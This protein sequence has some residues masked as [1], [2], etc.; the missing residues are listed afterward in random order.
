MQSNFFINEKPVRALVAL[1]EK[2]RT[3][4][5]SLLAKDVDCT[6]AHMVNVLDEFAS[7]GLVVFDREGRIKI[8]KLTEKGE[9]LAREFETVLRRI[10]KISTVQKT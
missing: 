2:D 3:W 9:D 8:V 7:A 5:A 10:E 1:S 4:Y 6:Y